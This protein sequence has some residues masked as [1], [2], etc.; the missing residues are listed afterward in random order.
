MQEASKQL[1]PVQSGLVALLARSLFGAKTPLPELPDPEHLLE[2]AEKQAVFPCVWQALTE[3]AGVDPGRSWLLRFQKHLTHNVNVISQHFRAHELM[4]E[5]GIPYTVIKGC[6]SGRYYPA[7]ELRTMGDVDL[8]VARDS[9]E[10]V[11]DFLCGKGYRVSNL[12]H[13]H[14][15]TFRTEYEEF[16]VH[17]LPSGLPAADDGTIGSLF[18]DMLEKRVL[19]ESCGSPMYLPDDFH[20][21]LILLLHTANHLSAGGIGLRQL[22]DWL[23]FV[24]GMPEERFLEL[25]REPLQRIGLWHFAC[26]LTAIGVCFFSC[27]P[28]AFCEEVSGE[29]ALQILLDIFT[30]GNFGVKDGTRMLESKLLRDEKTREIDG[31]GTFRHLIRFLNRKANLAMP[32]TKKHPI[33]LPAGWVKVGY[34]HLKTRNRISYRGVDLRRVAENAKERERLYAQLRLFKD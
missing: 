19:D 7:P 28:R 6:A 3:L 22:M 11:R 27:E 15:W 8:Y 10:A 14:H 26:V 9:M 25:F 13:S 20:H 12:H 5:A 1:T 31:G 23:V 4:T 2:E 21:G 17:W 16:E 32:A 30:G 29:L 34:R 33:L 18:D 24:N